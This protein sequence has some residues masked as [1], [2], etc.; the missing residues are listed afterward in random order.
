MSNIERVKLLDGQAN[1][2]THEL[3]ADVSDALVAEW[4]ER[5]YPYHSLRP[6]LQFTRRKVTAAN[7]NRKVSFRLQV[8]VGTVV[9]GVAVV[10]SVSTFAGSFTQNANAPQSHREDFFAMSRDLLVTEDNSLTTNLLG[11][12]VM[13]DEWPL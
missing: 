9:D 3:N 6:T 8:P 5:S 12:I 7:P 2:G 1:P 11:S 13:N 4:N 10:S